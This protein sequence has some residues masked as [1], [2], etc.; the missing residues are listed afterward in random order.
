MTYVRT[1]MIEQ[2]KGKG[3]PPTPPYNKAIIN[4]LGQLNKYT[5]K[6]KQPFRARAYLIAKTEIEN[7]KTD[8]TSLDQTAS[9]PNI[10]K[11]IQE[12]LTEFIN[13]GTITLEEASGTHIITDQTQ[14]KDD[15]QDIR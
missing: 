12:K 6:I 10:G 5:T 14:D 13:T 7:V 9:L 4:I 2:G 1:A 11:G 15:N 8:I 3:I